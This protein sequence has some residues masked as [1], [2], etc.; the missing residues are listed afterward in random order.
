MPIAHP[1][2]ARAVG[3]GTSRRPSGR[4]NG[5][6]AGSNPA[7]GTPVDGHAR[8]HETGT[9]SCPS[10]SRNG[11]SWPNVAPRRDRSRLGGGQPKPLN[12][13]GLAAIGAPCPQKERRGGG[14]EPPEEVSPL[15]GLANQRAKRPSACRR[16]ACVLARGPRARLRTRRQ[17]AGPRSLGSRLRRSWRGTHAGSNRCPVGQKRSVSEL[18]I[19]ICGSFQVITGSST[20]S[21]AVAGSIIIPTHDPAAGQVR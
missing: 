12:G 18:R 20:H 17:R 8:G 19:Q 16:S 9:N 10:V 4:Q 1:V 21:K 6:R 7:P 11:G 15:T 3:G 13:N 14:F 5:R 2:L